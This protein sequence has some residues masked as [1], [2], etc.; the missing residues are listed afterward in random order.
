MQ[1]E[2]FYCKNRIC[3][4]N[5]LLLQ[6]EVIW[7]RKTIFSNWKE[8]LGIIY[9]YNQFYSHVYGRKILF[10]TN[11]EPLATMSSL[12]NPIGRLVWLMHRLQDVDYWIVYLPGAENFL[13]DFLS[14]FFEEQN[15]EV[16]R[17][18]YRI[19]IKNWLGWGAKLRPQYSA[20][21][22]LDLSK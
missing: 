16:N 4:L 1:L 11:H 20:N 9:A 13:P 15:R 7:N 10:Y 2:R 21:N 12:K 8:F 18:Q 3:F 22:R 14:R 17:K 5:L 6:Q 19:K